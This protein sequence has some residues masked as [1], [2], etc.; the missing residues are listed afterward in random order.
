[1]KTSA[2]LKLV[3]LPCVVYTTWWM[4]SSLMAQQPKK[5]VRSTAP[6]SGKAITVDIPAAI[7][8]GPRGL[9]SNIV[10]L[11]HLEETSMEVDGNFLKV[12]ASVS[13][14]SRIQGPHHLWR[15]QVTDL[16]TKELVTD[17]P[18][19]DQL[20]QMDPSGVMKPTFDELLELPSGR[21]QVLLS[22]SRVP[23]GVDALDFLRVN[24]EASAPSLISIPGTIEIP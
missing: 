22:L 7:A 19:L 16:K 6:V 17:V 1:M 18:Y 5:S 8:A 10:S 24:N 15:L 20:F 4:T 21:Y 11:N 23:Y 13:M 14:M 2:S 12:H 3:V 9:H